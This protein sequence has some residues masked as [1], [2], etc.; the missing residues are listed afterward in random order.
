MLHLD[1]M[2][3]FGDASPINLVNPVYTPTA[4]FG[5]DPYRDAYVTQNQVALY[6]QDQIKIDR[7]TIVLSGRN[8]W[9]GTVDNDL[10]RSYQSREA[11]K[12]SGRGGHYI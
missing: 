4:P 3:G 10:A 7:L 9:V 2:Q 5:G 6:L 12:F 1:D 11:S 8:D